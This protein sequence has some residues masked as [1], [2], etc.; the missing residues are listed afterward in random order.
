MSN[1]QTLN[2]LF[3]NT[4]SFN[5]DDFA[6]K[7]PIVRTGVKEY[8]SASEQFSGSLKDK[9]LADIK[10]DTKLKIDN[11]NKSYKDLFGSVASVGQSYFSDDD[12]GKILS[13]LYDKEQQEFIL[14]KER[15]TAIENYFSGKK[16]DKKEQQKNNKDLKRY[17]SPLAA[18]C[19]LLMVLFPD[20]FCPIPTPD[21]VDYLINKLINDKYLNKADIKKLRSNYKGWLIKWCVFNNI[22]FKIFTSDED[23]E[24]G[25]S[26]WEAIVRYGREEQRK[27]IVGLLEENHNI[28][29][30][31]A[32][33]T[34]K[35]YRAKEIAVEM[36]KT[37]T[38]LQ[39]LNGDVEKDFIELQ[40][41]GYVD[42]VQFHPSY[43]YSDFVE[44]LRPKASVDGFERKDGIFKAFCAKAANALK[45]ENTKNNKYVFIIDEINRGEISKIFG[46]LFFS[47]D[48]GYRGEKG[49]VVT[50][51][52]NLIKED[53]RMPDKPTIEYPFIKGFYVPENV[54]IIGTMNDIDR[55]VESMDFAFRRR[56]AFKEIKAED[57]K[58][59]L[60]NGDNYQVLEDVMDRVNKE[61]IKTQYGLSE[62]Y[63]IG[64]SYFNKIKK[65]NCKSEYDYSK[66]LKNL[67]EYH[68]KGLLYEYLR[69]KPNAFVLLDQLK[70]SYFGKEPNTEEGQ[71]IEDNVND[72]QG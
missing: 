13:I 26:P 44:G 30:T 25:V 14:D 15:L 52:Q 33:G 18:T 16:N 20:Y 43:D 62:A 36:A 68:I 54:F 21:K 32:P 27:E 50:Q 69:G 41:Q 51:Y 12:F 57:S 6:N 70:N 71:E 35:T 34:G 49:K 4:I 1:D 17:A 5:K 61:L 24:N 72:T 47:I 63:Q 37:N 58:A 3:D 60:W 59:M 48:P 45:D 8:K 38:N 46:E 67:W 31:G 2:L 65:T 11:D 29:L 42:F 53:E 22:L 9:K 64:A 7:F 55:S 66:E 39:N 56:F 40:K 23:K 19:R 10:E 28:I